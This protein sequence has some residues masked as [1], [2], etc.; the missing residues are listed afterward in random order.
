M[1]GIKRK[2]E[3]VLK[4]ASSPHR[5]GLYQLICQEDN[6]DLDPER[7][8]DDISQTI[9]PEDRQRIVDWVGEL[10]F[11]EEYGV[12][13]KNLEKARPYANLSRTIQKL[14]DPGPDERWLDVGC[15]PLSMSQLICGEGTSNMEIYAIDIVL[16]PAMEKLAELAKEGKTLPVKLRYVSITDWMPYPDDFFDGIGANLVLPYVTD[17]CGLKGEQAL[18]G[19]LREMFRIL[20]PGG[21]LVWSTPTHSVNFNWVFLASLP[22]MLN[23]YRY[24][25][26][27]DFSRLLQGV[28]I[29]K[30]ALAI[31]RKGRKGI[32]TFLP[33]EELAGLLAHIGF[34][35]STWERTFTQQVWVNRVRKPYPR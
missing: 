25:K 35:K 3:K 6:C 15:G 20:K 11:W 1:Q 21:T 22:D 16:K 7:V 27:R 23:I 18:E 19:V 29:L 31:Q 17:F 13:Y 5:Q 9:S 30:H 12:V 33:K 14:L 28:K 26:D 2:T 8:L 32:Y 4:F 34:V 10:R 24:I